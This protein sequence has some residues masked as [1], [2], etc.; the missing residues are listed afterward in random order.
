MSSIIELYTYMRNANELV[1]KIDSLSREEFIADEDITLAYFGI[2]K[3]LL[4]YIVKLDAMFMVHSE[5][6]ILV[7]EI[8]EID[9]FMLNTYKLVNSDILYDFYKVDY[10]RLYKIVTELV[11]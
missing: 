8:Y 11:K 10:K 3:D 2:F 5:L 1:K 4:T 7:K 6:S 9:R